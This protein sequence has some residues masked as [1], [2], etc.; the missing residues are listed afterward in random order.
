M[1]YYTVITAII[2]LV[3]SHVGLPCV[4]RDFGKG[5]FVCV[6]NAT[7]CDSVEP[8]IPLQRGQFA[9][10]HSSKTSDRL[11]KSDGIFIDYANHTS[12]CK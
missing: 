5:S 12:K 10:Y 11:K 3:L 1:Q 8:N 4:E 9:F 2:I 6:C 7:Y